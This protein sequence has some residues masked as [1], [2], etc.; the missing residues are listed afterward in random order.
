VIYWSQQVVAPCGGSACLHV[1]AYTGNSGGSPSLI[2][3]N[4]LTLINVGSANSQG[5]VADASNYYITMPDAAGTPT[6]LYKLNKSLGSVGSVNITNPSQDMVDDGSFLYT[7]D[8][9]SNV[10]R[11]IEKTTLIVT[12]FTFGTVT[13]FTGGIDYHLNS[14]TLYASGLVGGVQQVVQ[15]LKSTMTIIGSVN[16]NPETVVLRGLRI[17]Q[18]ADKLYAMT[19]N[20]ASWAVR[21]MNLAPFANAQTI[22]NTDGGNTGWW[23]A[24]DFIHKALW[25]TDV[26]SPGHLHKVSLCS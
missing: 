21:R 14:D 26:D 10:I 12:S 17:D 22:T 4:A 13:N 3:D 2:L 9:I 5:G 1:K 15:I 23:M 16:I 20:G 25:F 19:A 24:P 7:I 18:N 11:R 8:G 6:R